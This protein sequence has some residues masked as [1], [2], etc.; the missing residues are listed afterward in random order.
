MLAVLRHFFKETEDYEVVQEESLGEFADHES[1][2]DA[3]VLKILARP[4]GSTYS[5]DYCLVESK[6]LGRNW[7]ETED[8]LSRHCGGTQN[9]S[10]R[11]YGIVHVGLEIKFFRGNAGWLEGI[12]Q[13]LHLRR[14]VRT[15]AEWFEFLKRNPLPLQ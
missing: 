6:K 14:D 10:R 15:I 11:V 2:A 4:G 7:A 5:Y 13:P 3:S 12:S 1:R 9:E 8:Q